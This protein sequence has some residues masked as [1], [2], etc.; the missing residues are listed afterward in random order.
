MTALIARE[1]R[2][3]ELGPIVEL[4]EDGTSVGLVYLDEGRL[5]AEFVAEVDGD[6]WAYEVD[7]LH[8]ALDVAASMLAPPEPEEPVDDPDAPHP[9]DRLATVFDP[10]A[11][12]RGEEDEGFFPLP[13]AVAMVR[14]A[15]ELDLAVVSLEGFTVNEGWIAP[16]SGCDVDIGAAHDGE[17]WPVFKAGCNVQAEAVLERWPRKPG[18]GV[19]VEV[20]D[21]SGERYVM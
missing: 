16:V 11:I 12:R 19:A 20:A 4:V 6:R 5:Y 8:R 7:D 10:Q 2:H 13:V 9:V 3:P 18:F 14:A 17:P 21:A 1:A 15:S